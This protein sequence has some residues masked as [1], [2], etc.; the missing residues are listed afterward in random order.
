MS[1]LTTAEGVLETIYAL[2]G[3]DAAGRGRGGD[4][5]RASARRAA[6][7]AAAVFYGIWPARRGRPA[8][9]STTGGTA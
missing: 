4:L 2:A 3:V 6:S 8:H 7:G 5:S 9:S 1:R